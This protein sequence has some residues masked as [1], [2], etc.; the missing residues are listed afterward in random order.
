VAQAYV[1]LVELSRLREVSAERFSCELAVRDGR[2]LLHCLQ[3]TEE[4]A[5]GCFTTSQLIA[6]HLRENS[7]IVI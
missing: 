7:Q 2:Q 3:F 6:K 1:R 4:E 5:H